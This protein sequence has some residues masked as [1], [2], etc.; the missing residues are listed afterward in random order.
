MVVKPLIK[1]NIVPHL[2][3]ALPTFR[4]VVLQGP[5]QSGKTTVARQMAE[6]GSFLAL[7]NPQDR[8]LAAA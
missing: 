2:R 3:E 7:D 6:P 4:V 1:R 5:R 8:Q